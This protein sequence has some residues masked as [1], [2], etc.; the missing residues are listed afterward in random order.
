MAQIIVN[1][2]AGVVDA[3]A[4]G[5]LAYNKIIENEYDLVLMDLQMPV[6]NGYKA[7]E[8]IRNYERM[9]NK[10]PVKIV[11]MTANAMKDDEDLCL[12]IGMDAYLS[13]PFRMEDMIRILKMLHLINKSQGVQIS[14]DE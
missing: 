10:V 4:N 6:L 2:F 12:N 1:P 9:N 13:K 14:V 5:L 7:T 11:A 8:M 3:A